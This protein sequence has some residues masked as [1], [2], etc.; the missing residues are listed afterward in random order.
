VN[1]VLDIGN[2]SIK[3]GWFSGTRLLHY[4]VFSSDFPSGNW[5]EFNGAKP[6]SVFY[7]SVRKK[8]PEALLNLPV[9]ARKLI[10]E[11]PLP[12]RNLY[13]SPETLGPDRLANAVGGMLRFPGKNVIILDA[14]TC[15][16]TDVVVADGAY[17]GGA[18]SPGLRMRYKALH[19]FTEKLPL[20]EPVP[21]TPLTGGNTSESIHSGVLHGMKAEM[22]GIM[23]EYRQVY[24]DPVFILT[25]GDHAVFLSR[26]KSRIFAAPALTLEGLNAILLHNL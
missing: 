12:I 18:I 25:G 4:Q 7:C 14:G 9:S 2:T 24:I 23:D 22:E 16:K 1:L 19:S 20:L 6:G 10:H 3:A 17:M 13:Q 8:D 26:T 5:W 21:D 11:T 15:L